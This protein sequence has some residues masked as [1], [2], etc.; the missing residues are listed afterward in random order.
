MGA[1]A[2][3]IVKFCKDNGLR[4][5]GQR[6]VVVKVLLQSTDHPDALELHRRVTKIDPRIS[7]STIYRTLNVLEAKGVLE[8]HNFGDGPARFE[9]VDQEHHD[10]LIDV[11]TGKVLEFRSDEIERLQQQ[12]AQQ[13]GFEI[14][15]HKLEIYVRPKKPPRRKS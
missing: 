15:S 2:I 3:D 14:I 12:I 4:L 9:A 5:T 10:H 11:T 13:H 6:R 7:L 1:E 8:K